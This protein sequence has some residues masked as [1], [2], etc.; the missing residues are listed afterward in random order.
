VRVGPARNALPSLRPGHRPFPPKHDSLDVIA[1]RQGAAVHV[2]TRR[3]HGDAHRAGVLDTRAAHE[4]GF[5]IAAGT[6]PP[7][8]CLPDIPIQKTPM[9][10]RPHAAAGVLPWVDQEYRFGTFYS[11]IRNQSG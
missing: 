10:A 7:L 4:T 8:A 2:W 9:P 1:G 11:F 3:L 6:D 5:P